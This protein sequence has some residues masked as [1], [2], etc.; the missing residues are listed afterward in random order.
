MIKV[1][2]KFKLK[3]G[4]DIRPTL[5]KM[6]TDMITYVGF[7]GVEHLIDVKNETHVSVIS[8]W[9]RIEDWTVWETSKVRKAI[10]HE[11]EMVLLEESKYYIFKQ[12]P[13]IH[14]VD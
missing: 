1:I 12:M 8:S 2:D 5:M 7:L 13:L 6:R 10:L 9:D 11:A 3:S 4:A 14:W